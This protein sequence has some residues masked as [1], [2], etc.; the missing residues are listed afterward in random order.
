MRRIGFLCTLF[1]AFTSFALALQSPELRQKVAAAKE[2]AARN[3]QALRG[4]SWISKTDVL[5][6]GEVKNTKIESCQYGPDGTVQKTEI[7]E[8]AAPAR[9]RRGLRGRVAAKQTAEMQQEMQ[10]AAALVRS[11]V[12]PAPDKLQAVMAAG[13]VSLTR[14]GD[15]SVGLRFADYEKS[16]DSLALTLDSTANTLQRVSVDTWTGEPTN[17]VTLEVGFQSLSDGTSY[18]ASTVLKIPGEEIEVHIN[19]SDFAKPAQ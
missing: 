14:A 11:Y 19:N 1:C 2:A 13:G 15:G 17:Q 10:S 3:Q 6:K 18:A 12:P 9:R 5:V 8:P 16:G 7:S 4:Y